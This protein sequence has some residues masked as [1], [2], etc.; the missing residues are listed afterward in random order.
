MV[1]ADESES[2]SSPQ[3]LHIHAAIFKG[4]I[5]CIHAPTNTLQSTSA[6]CKCFQDLMEKINYFQAD[7]K[8]SYNHRS[9]HS[10]SFRRCI[11]RNPFLQHI[12]LAQAARRLRGFLKKGQSINEQ[13]HRLLLLLGLRT[14][15]ASSKLQGN[16]ILHITNHFSPFTGEFLST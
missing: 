6:L 8:S 14:D 5:D 1:R 9:L 15:E 2:E 16:D 13:H 7:V 4:G 12:K 3:K 11:C 10:D